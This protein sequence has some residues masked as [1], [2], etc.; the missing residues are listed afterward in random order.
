MMMPMILMHILLVFG[1][2]RAPRRLP[3][4]PPHPTRGVVGVP[5]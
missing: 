5:R 4:I 2:L 3:I 1:S